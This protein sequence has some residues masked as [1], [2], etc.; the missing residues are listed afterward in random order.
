MRILAPNRNTPVPEMQRILLVTMPTYFHPA[1]ER[2]L[3]GERVGEFDF[4]KLNFWKKVLVSKSFVHN[5][6]SN[7]R[8]IPYMADLAHYF[9][10]THAPSAEADLLAD[11]N[12]HRE[13]PTEFLDG[14]ENVWEVEQEAFFPWPVD[15]STVLAEREYDT[16]LLLYADANGL[17]WRKL[18]KRMGKLNPARVLVLNGRKRLFYLDAATRRKLLWR[19]FWE[20]SWLVEIALAFGL[21]LI[22]VPLVLYDITL[23]KFVRS[24]AES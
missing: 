18:E 14:F 3:A 20:R 16:I 9:L 7:P 22:A 21:L 19:R 6:R 11:V 10:Q 15:M 12:A 23:G 2:W 13:L 8:S 5:T 24:L 1:W 4:Y 17:G